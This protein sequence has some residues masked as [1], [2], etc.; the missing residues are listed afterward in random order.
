MFDVCMKNHQVFGLLTQ[1]YLQLDKD[2][3]IMFRFSVFPVDKYVVITTLKSNYVEGFNFSHQRFVFAQL[4]P[5]ISRKL[6]KL[7]LQCWRKNFPTITLRKMTVK[8]S[9]IKKHKLW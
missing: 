3:S 1:N 6:T 8:A 5:D 9:R 4:F 7:H 2:K